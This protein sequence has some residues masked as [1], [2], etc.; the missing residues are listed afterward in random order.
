M[1][2][3]AHKHVHGGFKDGIG[4]SPEVGLSSAEKNDFDRTDGEAGKILKNNSFAGHS[5][6]K[7]IPDA[8]SPPHSRTVKPLSE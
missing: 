2:D 4:V 7:A 1:T 6:R 8:E 5:S 3:K